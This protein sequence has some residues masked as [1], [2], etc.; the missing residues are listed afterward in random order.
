MED[1]LGLEPLN[2]GQRVAFAVTFLV[3]AFGLL[4]EVRRERREGARTYAHAATAVTAALLVVGG[5]YLLFPKAAA[6]FAAALGG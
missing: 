6:T 4:W 3:V 5:L 1:T 2:V